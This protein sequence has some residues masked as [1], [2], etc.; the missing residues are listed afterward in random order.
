MYREKIQESRPLS[1]QLKRPILI[2]TLE[3]QLKN[4]KKDINTEISRQLVLTT[5][6]PVY[7]IL[8]PKNI[9]I[10]KLINGKYKI[11]KYIS[12]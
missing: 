5:F 3:F 4:I 2:L 9:H 1:N 6:E 8:L 11:I 12:S 7:P 10:K